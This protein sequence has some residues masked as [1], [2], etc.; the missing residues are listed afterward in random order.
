MSS[1]ERQTP[2]AG[3][4]GT[5]ASKEEKS[6]RPSIGRT[7]SA[8]QA[9][10]DKERDKSLAEA[11]ARQLELAAS[12][13][14]KGKETFLVKSGHP[15]PPPS[16]NLPPRGSSSGNLQSQKERLDALTAKCRNVMT[17]LDAPNPLSSSSPSSDPEPQPT[18]RVPYTRSIASTLQKHADPR[19][20]L[21]RL[22]RGLQPYLLVRDQKGADSWNDEMI[23]Q[24]QHAISAMQEEIADL[25]RLPR[26]AAP[27]GDS[28]KSERDL[29][30]PRSPKSWTAMAMARSRSGGDVR[31]LRGSGRAER[32]W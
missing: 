8:H 2:R 14:A 22:E 12:E 21:P 29:T 28:G 11:F 9:T 25:Y 6:S 5:F 23:R 7:A 20:A 13:L 24:Y 18:P 27:A 15:I 32:S 4:K 16:N 31:G 3:S 1:G 30:L 10:T 19:Q 17:V 26:A